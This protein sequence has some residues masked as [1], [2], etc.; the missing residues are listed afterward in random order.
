MLEIKYS[1]KAAKQLKKIA[2][3][4]LRDAER[5]IFAIENYA[6]SP[7]EKHDIKHLKGKFGEFIRLRMGNYRIIFENE[8]NIMFVYDIKHR[9]D[10]YND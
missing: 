2:K 3:S 9:K 7:L 1:E 8:N 6:L 10:I 5:I 4:N